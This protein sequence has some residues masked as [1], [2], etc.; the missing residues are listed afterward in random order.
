MP[1]SIIQ[2]F[3]AAMA[4]HPQVPDAATAPGAAPLLL[5]G[6]HVALIGGGMV[7]RLQ[8]G[9]WFE[10]LLHARL[11]D[12]ELVVRNLGFSADELT[13]RQ[14]T[15]SFGSHDE[16]LTRVGATVVVAAF[17]FNESFAG[18]AGL[19]QFRTDLLAFLDHVSA[20][21]FDG[22]AAPRVVLV[23]PIAYEPQSEPLRPAAGPMNAQLAS[24]SAAI[25]EV[26]A[27]R[28]VPFIDAF[29]PL[30]RAYEM[31][32]EPLTING[33]HLNDAGD[34]VLAQVLVAALGGPVPA[35]R[36]A[37]TDLAASALR[38]ATQE[39]ARLWFNRYQATDGYNVYGG[40]SSLSFD[41]V[42]NFVVLQR[43]ME[44]LDA[45]TAAHD[46]QLWSLARGQPAALDTSDVPDAIPVGTNYPGPL[47][48]GRHEFLDGAKAIEQMTP[49]PGTRVD[50]FADEKHFPLLAKPV[51]MAW[52]PK[53]RLFVAVWPSYPHW[54]PGEAM[55]DKIVILED[56]DGDGRADACKTFAG[57]LHNPTGIEFWNGGLFVACAPDLWFL[58]DT[59]GDDVADVRERV[60]H[61]LSSGDTHHS[62]NSFVIGPDGGLYFQEGTFHQSQIETI[63]GPERNH[64]ACVWR[65]D[66]K[67]FRVE[68]H[69]AYNFANPHGHVFDRFGQEFMTDGTGND[70]YWAPA[71]SGRVIHPDKHRGYF[72]FFPQRSR[73]CGATEILSS[74]HFPPEYQE[75]YLV[76]NVIGFLG[77]FQYRI[78]D[79]GAGFGAEE[80]APIVVSTDPRFRPVDAEV[81][82]DGSLYFLDW[83]NPIIGHMQH[84]LRDPN[85]DHEHGRVYRVT[86]VGR[87]LL[88]PKSVA[89]EPVEALIALLEEPENRVRYRARIELS[90]RESSAVVA[91]ARKWARS[92]PAGEA[93]DAARLE[94]LWVM[95][96]HGVVE[97]P[98]L[99]ALLKSGD[100]RVRAAAVRVIRH[101]RNQLA[102]PAVRLLVLAR[103]DHPRVRL[104]TLI[105]AS[106]IGG[107]TAAQAAFDVL[108]LPQD[109]FLLYA[110]GETMRT[111]EPD[112]R[113]AL[114][115]GQLAVADNEA[116]VNWLVDRA[117]DDELAQLPRS[118]AVLE[119]LVARHGT[120]SDSRRAAL[121][122]L[123]Q[124]SHRTPFAELVRA[125]ERVDRAGGEHAR[126]V[127][128]ALGTELV[129]SVRGLGGEF[130]LLIVLA[131]GGRLPE[132][133]AF[134]FAA[135][136][137]GSGSVERVWHDAA[138]EPRNLISLLGAL[139]QLPES[140]AEAAWT[141]ARPLQFAAGGDGGGGG[142][143]RGEA[144]LL[145][146]YYVTRLR[147]ATRET[148]AR[149]V[150]TASVVHDA[151]T[152]ALPKIDKSDA[153]ALRFRTTLHVPVAGEWRFWLA[154]DDG[155]RLWIDG[156][157]V[158][159]N[160][161]DHGVVEKSGVVDLAA[162]AHALELCYFDAGGAEG[163]RLQWAGPSVARQEI[164]KERL[165]AAM[166]D[167]LRAAAV[168]AIAKVP[169]HEAEK[170]A[171]AARLLD[172]G[173]LAGEAVELL[174]SLSDGAWSDAARTSAIG[175]ALVRFARSVPAEQRTRGDVAAALD[176]AGSLLAR[177][178]ADGARA[179]R[180]ELRELAGATHV[181]RTVPHQ[182][183][184]DKK[185]IVVAAGQPVAIVFQNND[186]MPHNLVVGA[187]GSLELIGTAAE[188]MAQQPGAQE[189]SFVPVLPEVLQVIRLLLPGES[190]T[191]R[192]VAPAQPGDYPF[193]CT[194]PGHWRVMNGVVRVVMKLSEEQLDAPVAVSEPLPA[195][196]TR[197]FV[198]LWTAEDFAAAFDDGWDQRRNASRG[199]AVIE[200]AGCIQCHWFRGLGQKSAPDLS[201]VATK[202]RD[203]LLLKQLLEP[204]AAIL[205]G[206]EQQ[207]WILKDGRDVLGR[208]IREDAESYTVSSDLRHPEQVTRVRK[209][210]IGKQKKSS[211]SAMPTGLLVTFTKDEILDLVALLQSPPPQ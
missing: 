94:A 91:A 185:E 21:S 88:T 22:A 177:Q 134:A 74:R 12:H 162:G 72:T 102:D 15:E 31:H 164:A 155:S 169:G 191:L 170:L 5:K 89:G 178:P 183:L 118:V 209:S 166:A 87:P 181:I 99:D 57:G 66:P 150:P 151:I 126:H 106:W 117:S 111:L 153:F 25:R 142:D 86:A 49:A 19:P 85:R 7:E 78:V 6:D 154:T 93:G 173:L 205:E 64:D 82:P 17:G 46:R 165:E 105:A 20:Q 62:A 160:D 206:Y 198:K 81:A 1:C 123:A 110:F 175:D 83:C 156:N 120:D 30:A 28:G 194:F 163:L 145:V 77:I 29:A 112:W 139:E 8:H 97:E 201:T 168:R 100:A 167:V 75:S 107:A 53:G 101:G 44:I 210:D 176:L 158:I 42:T 159:E 23:S 36:S 65:F 71:F 48:G 203:A 199:R 132:T 172:E 125:M 114:S 174:R 189:K 152:T 10:T 14:R 195:A 109:K 76:C 140:F 9:G 204:S 119:A 27:R 147:D 137:K 127:Q 92:R 37:L 4:A 60:L 3:L 63:W 35:D 207:F 190:T 143:P 179:R 196:S 43:E 133:A 108:R 56:K 211:L 141:K 186:L 41:G 16:W 84:H 136:M 200:E 58:K 171:D 149:L 38:A 193:V 197:T 113:A 24:Y 73:P 192:F 69:I 90:G 208:I 115:A 135:L 52:D 39:K 128:H 121:Q 45:L 18:E 131:E 148:F 161:G 33:I 32:A 138:T 51:Q 67:S 146:D 54:A 68:R 157:E 104:E 103:D 116:A 182:M 26:A 2:W 40:R 34:A 59:D 124:K 13:V 61:G 180:R 188:A 184:Y 50:L 11:P 55:D 95:Q 144:G 122:Q 187:P 96:E 129:A 98:L 70:N 202:F 130:D 47:A 79:D 80:L